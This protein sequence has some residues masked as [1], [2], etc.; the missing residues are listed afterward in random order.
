M[1]ARNAI[2]GV[3]HAL[4]VYVILVGPGMLIAIGL[5]F[6][7]VSFGKAEAALAGL[8]LTA[9]LVTGVIY[10]GLSIVFAILYSP[11]WLLL[12][13]VPVTQSIVWNR[14]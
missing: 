5:A 12:L 1:N 4:F 2:M 6:C 7:G 13:L 3:L 8:W 11:W 10:A 14:T 9:I